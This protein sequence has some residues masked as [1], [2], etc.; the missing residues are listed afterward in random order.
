MFAANVLLAM[1]WG[2]LV[3]LILAAT[4]GLVALGLLAAL[5]PP[6]ALIT[7]ALVAWGLATIVWI[8]N[9][10]IAGL[11][12]VAKIQHA[13]QLREQPIEHDRQ[14]LLASLRIRD[15]RHTTDAS[16]VAEFLRRRKGDDAGTGLSS[17]T[18]RSSSRRS[19]S[20]TPHTTD[21]SPVAEFLRRR[22]GDDAGT[23][24][25]DLQEGPALH[26]RV[27]G[28]T[29]S[30]SRSD[31]G[32]VVRVDRIEHLSGRVGQALSRRPATDVEQEHVGLA[33]RA[34]LAFYAINDAWD[35]ESQ[36]TA[37][38]LAALAARSVAVR[39]ELLAASLGKLA[40]H[41]AEGGRVDSADGQ[42]LQRMAATLNAVQELGGQDALMSATSTA[43]IAAF[44]VHEFSED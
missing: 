42:F 44:L 7:M 39:A 1:L 19:E 29:E 41:Q 31:E 17:T 36:D 43:A 8:V 24:A 12:N 27:R 32:A 3:R 28:S 11:A 15:A 23:G 4:F 2:V 16:P 5:G 10:T 14:E 6:D 30:A 34:A 18:G 38:E 20:A 9:G 25:I 37:D 13:Q 21:A 33:L 40:V 26:E 22:K 35:R